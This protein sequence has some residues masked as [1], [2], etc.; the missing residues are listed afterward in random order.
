MSMSPT[1]TTAVPSM[2]KNAVRGTAFTLAAQVIKFVTQLGSTVLLARLLA[3]ADFGIYA[4][5]TPVIAIA[6]LIQDLGLTQAVVTARTIDQRAI[7]MMFYINLAVSALVGGTLLLAS[8]A[9]ADFYG[10]D[11]VIQVLAVM[12]YSVFVT[13]ASSVHRALLN[14][15]LRY[16]RIA[17]IEVVAMAGGA[18]M[19]IALAFFVSG[20]LALV[21]AHAT[22]A[23]LLLVLGWTSTRWLPGRPAPVAA[24][25]HFLKF[26]GGLTGFNITNFVSRSADNIIIGRFLG[27][28]QLGYYDRAYKLML[29]PLQQVNNPTSRVMVPILSKLT[30][31]PDRYRAAYM[32]TLRILL[33]VTLP[34]VVFFATA[35]DPLIP[36]VL[37]NEWSP[38]AEVFAWLSIAALHQPLS[39]TL[40]WLFISQ[41]R[42][43][44]FAKWG[45]FNAVTCVGAFFAGLPWGAVGVAAA[46]AISDLGLRMPVLW[47]YVGRS[48]P[49]RTKH[50][51]QLAAPYAV[52]L[53]L[54]AGVLWGLHS[55]LTLQPI[56][57]L[58]VM[59][60]AA[61]T[62]FWAVLASTSRGRATFREII[63]IA[64]NAIGRSRPA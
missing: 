25:V 27:S 39:A 17:Q 8:Q 1:G 59:G 5:A 13:G 4:M 30:D 50:L 28:T 14:R 19:S 46:Y 18:I 23:S 43:G 22:Q 48:G 63:G 45:V 44:A 53:I 21:S 15:E 49:V 31:D 24:V 54:S 6:L 12:A 61:Y 56:A 20:P 2:R 38:A 41:R 58:A 32:R 11:R 52:A 47:W 51:Y 36:A 60:S 62:V 16:G 7:S 33:L 55:V 40:G 42:T 35:A 34:G 3:P 29:M 57:L 64:Q 26:G 10:T 37:G 9:I